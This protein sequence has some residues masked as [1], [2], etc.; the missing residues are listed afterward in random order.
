MSLTTVALMNS[1][2]VIAAVA[3]LA[4]VCRVPFRLKQPIAD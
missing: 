2:L 4:Y 1:I 3:A